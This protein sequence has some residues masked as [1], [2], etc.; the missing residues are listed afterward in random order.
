MR[1][2]VGVDSGLDGS[3]PEMRVQLRATLMRVPAN[4][5]LRESARSGRG[6]KAPFALLRSGRSTAFPQTVLVPFAAERPNHL[7]QPR[8][9]GEAFGTWKVVAAQ[10]V[11]GGGEFGF[12]CCAG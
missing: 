1:R 10:L 2:D 5:C 12:R 3:A 4:D 7:A 8:S 9:I 11:Q 6:P